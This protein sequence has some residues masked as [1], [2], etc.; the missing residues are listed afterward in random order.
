MTDWFEIRVPRSTKWQPHLNATF[1]QALFEHINT[2]MD[3]QLVCTH[4]QVRWILMSD[5][6]NSLSHDTVQTLVSGYFPGAEVLDPDGWTLELPYHRRVAV[7]SRSD[8]D[9]YETFS[10]VLMQKGQDHFATLLQTLAHLEPGEVLTYHVFITRIFELSHDEIF[11]TLTISAH[12]GGIRTQINAGYR[13]DMA[14]FAGAMI[15]KWFQDRK[16]KKIPIWRHDERDIQRYSNKLSQKLAEVNVYVRFDTPNK[17]RLKSLSDTTAAVKNMTLE[18][19][20]FLVDGMDKS[21]CVATEEAMHALWPG[22]II[23]NYLSTADEEKAAR[24]FP[25]EPLFILTADEVASLWHPPHEQCTASGIKWTRANIPLPPA[26]NNVPDGIVIGSNNGDTVKLPA[27]VQTHHGMVVGKTGTGKSS[28][29]QQMVAQYLALQQ[30]VLVIDPAGSLVTNILRYHIPPGRENDVV[31][32]DLNNIKYPAPLSPLY[33]PKGFSEDVAIDMLMSVMAKIDPDMTFKE[34]SDTMHMIVLTLAADPEANLLDVQRLLD[35]VAY[36]QRLIEKADDFTVTAFWDRYDAMSDSKQREFTRPVLRRLNTFY[37]NKA[38]RAI[39]CHPN[40]LNLRQLV[41]EGKIILVSL[42]ADEA[43]MPVEQRQLL[44]AMLVAQVQMAVMSG[45]IK[46][47]PFELVIDEAQHFVTTAL[48]TMLSEARK[49][50]MGILLSNQFSKQLTGNTLDAV[51]G[52]VAT[53]ISFEVGEPDAKVFV[54]YMKPEFQTMDLVKMGV[55]RAAVSTRYQNTRQPAFTLETLPPPQAN[56]GVDLEAA[57][58]REASLR[59]LSIENYTPMTYDEV[60]DWLRNRYLPA[61]A[62]IP[63]NEQGDDFLE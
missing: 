60:N 62:T 46:N 7:M 39:A 61:Q 19:E 3:L 18:G 57:K 10:S 22:T 23:Y 33:R 8:S 29:I 40:P 43:R 16:L 51:E 17:E 27:E 42:A 50:D 55:Y 11:D 41:S 5:D 2:W 36:R 35:D 58:A 28:L 63:A 13:M 24:M 25:R 26:L 31:V 47:P 52:N 1:M 21:G 59:Q 44:G 38:L 49:H 6:E 12:D 30:G 34:M 20:S 32:L 4:Q 56:G 15:G 53:L 9:F 14:E 54:P 48:D 37:R 45:A